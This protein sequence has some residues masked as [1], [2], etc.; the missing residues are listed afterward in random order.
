MCEYMCVCAPRFEHYK[1]RER[2]INQTA[3][4]AIYN[5]KRLSKQIK[6][7]TLSAAKCKNHAVKIGTSILKN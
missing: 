1:I 4:V 3:A 5:R 6:C 2:K 7:A